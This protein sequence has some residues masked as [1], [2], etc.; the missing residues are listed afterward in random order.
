[1][2]Y[3]RTGNTI[4]IKL[5]QAQKD[6]LKKVSG[7]ITDN[8]GEPIIGANVVQKGTTN[9]IITDVDGN[10]SLEIPEGTTLVISYIGY[11]SQEIHTGNQYVLK[12]KLAEDTQNLEEVVVVG[13]GV[14]EENQLDGFR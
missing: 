12:I 8:R 13:Y 5:I 7:T 9:G 14:Q 1:M 2:E 10:F 11:L 6:K 4:A 3:T